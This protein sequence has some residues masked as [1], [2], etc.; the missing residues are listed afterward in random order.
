MPDFVV[1][2]GPAA[3]ELAPELESPRDATFRYEHTAVL[4][5]YWKDLFRPELFWHTFR[6]IPVRD[7][8]TEAIHVFRRVIAADHPTA[9]HPPASGTDRVP[10]FPRSPGQPPEER[11]D[12]PMAFSPGAGV[13]PP[14]DL[15]AAYA[16]K[17]FG[18]VLYTQGKYEAAAAHFTEALRLNPDYADAHNNLGTILSRQGRYAEAVAHF[19]EAIRLRPDDPNAY[20]ESAM[21]MA[22]CPEAKFRDGKRAVEFATR[23]CEL[24]EWKNP[25]VLDTLA[26]AQAE[27]GDFDAAV[28]LAKAGDRTSD[29]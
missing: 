13:G 4:D 3:Q 8:A 23:A 2:F 22:A 9:P 27:A 28:K 29:G 16:H 10:A 7:P 1:L 11:L 5:T 20:N 18:N 26:A 24:T 17:N 25:Q 19:A 14:V 21:I 15:V 6:P 12:S